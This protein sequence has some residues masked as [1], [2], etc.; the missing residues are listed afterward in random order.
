MNGLELTFLGLLNF[1]CL[2]T[3]AEYDAF[4]ARLETSP[5]LLSAPNDSLLPRHHHFASQL[6]FSKSRC[7]AHTSP[8]ALSTDA[9]SPAGSP[10]SAP[11]RGPGIAA[12]AAQWRGKGFSLSTQSVASAASTSCLSE[13]SQAHSITSASS[14]PERALAPHKRR[15]NPCNKSRSLSIPS[16]AS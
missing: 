3:R 9:L 12:A 15:A 4:V 1:Q 2:V 16:D 10:A 13:V 6:H 5:R 7:G 11:P 8:F 14:A